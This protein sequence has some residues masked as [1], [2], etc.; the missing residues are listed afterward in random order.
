MG[1]ASTR[2]GSC[3]NPCICLHR[4]EDQSDPFATTLQGNR[5][6]ITKGSI[7]RKKPLQEIEQIN[8]ESHDTVKYY[9]QENHELRMQTS[10]DTKKP[11]E[12]ENINTCNKTKESEYC[13]M[14]RSE[15][16]LSTY[17]AQKE[18]LCSKIIITPTKSDACLSESDEDNDFNLKE[19]YTQNLHE[20]EKECYNLELSSLV[21]AK[22]Y[23]NE[24]L[25]TYENRSTSQFN[26][27]KET[28]E[29][30]EIKDP[31]IIPEEDSQGMESSK[32][33]ENS[34]MLKGSDTLTNNLDPNMLLSFCKT[35]DKC[36]DTYDDYNK[37]QCLDSSNISN[38]I[39]PSLNLNTSEIQKQLLFSTQQNS[40]NPNESRLLEKFSEFNHPQLDSHES[41]MYLQN[42]NSFLDEEK[43]E[44]QPKSAI[45]NFEETVNIKLGTVQLQKEKGPFKVDLSVLQTEHWYTSFGK[46]LKQL[47]NPHERILIEG[48]LHKYKPGID[49]MYI[50]RW[51]QLTKTSFRVYKNQVSAKGFNSKPLIAL[52]LEIFK[53]VKKARFSVPEKG[54]HLKFIKSLKKN[55]FEILYRDD[56]LDLI[57]KNFLHSKINERRDEDNIIELQ[58]DDEFEEK[59]SIL[60][61]KITSNEAF[62]VSAT[63]ETLNI[64]STWSNREGEWFCAEKRLM[65]STQKSTERNN[66]LKILRKYL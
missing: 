29:I 21:D 50:P 1:A 8:I 37:L 4:N 7:V 25:D 47:C 9:N 23:Q 12:K 3:C 14:N 51:C 61:D 28:E 41:Y 31:V 52:P 66:W 53:G 5:M 62:K 17:P 24:V 46:T 15:R 43:S 42:Q 22:S 65:F 36:G 30:P 13:T 49:K 32:I 59:I 56:I 11:F 34:V 54:K 16:A 35:L 57:M 6:R 38:I 45:V 10:P 39:S 20:D 19:N 26:L 33:L 60:K 18:S 64:P 48:E 2:R 58:D 40:V 44:K 55:Q 27:C 63:M